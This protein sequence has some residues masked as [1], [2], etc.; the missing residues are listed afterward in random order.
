M[1]RGTADASP[2]GLSR[3]TT[4]KASLGL[5]VF[6]GRPPGTCQE[7]DMKA[8]ATQSTSP[9]RLRRWVLNVASGYASAL[10]G[11][12][13]YLLLTPVL[14]DR[15]GVESYAVL[16]LC[17]TI[18]FYL[19][20]L[21]VGFAGAQIRFHARFAA[22]GNQDSIQRLT[23]TLAVALTTAGVVATALGL[24]IAFAPV[25]W[26]TDGSAQLNA[27]FR[28]VLGILA[29]GLFVGFPSAVLDNMYEG[30]QRFDIRNVRSIVLELL[31]A[32][33]QL[34][35]V[36]AGYG[37]VALVIVDLAAGCALIFIDVIVLQRLL[38]GM[39]QTVVRFDRGIWQR[40]RRFAF[41]NS[42]D[43][44]LIE[45]SPQVDKILVAV[46]LPLAALT[47]YSL[48]TTV[49]G[50]LLAAIYPITETFYP[51]ASS[52]HAKRRWKE[53]A[54]LLHA[55]T[56]GLVAVTAPVAIILACFGDALMGIWIPEMRNAMP[57]ALLPIVVADILISVFLSTSAVILIA[58]NGIRGFVVLT[59]VEVVLALLLIA[60]LTPSFGLNGL[61]CAA[62]LA[63]VVMGFAFQVP[64]VSKIVSTSS[65]GFVASTLLR[66]LVA[67]LPG[68]AV[69][70][71]LRKLY[72]D[73]GLANV[74]LSAALVGGVC[75]AGLMLIGTT[76]TERQRYLEW[77]QTAR[78]GS[79]DP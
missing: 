15:L 74:L 2:E 38:P 66:V 40:I 79:V 36:Q 31:T 57:P 21:D 27:D 1:G 64:M 26:W 75:L 65:S 46:F 14:I 5:Q 73:P 35:L 67:C 56:K 48:S 6:D 12:V 37:L 78:A 50:V 61:A 24:A 18:T 54:Q 20:F 23:G 70:L 51:L 76:R 41:W 10:V 59:L 58:C 39:M 62:L 32:G 77:W 47:P 28:L 60:I 43:D 3:A 19:Q 25:S 63:N 11:G 4:C 53:L 42:L 52:L 68:I 9:S 30:A 72:P 55:G 16:I 13:I 69:A 29:V 22:R 71:Y 45:G 8:P 44:L 49:A 17:H 33:T 34:L 7:L